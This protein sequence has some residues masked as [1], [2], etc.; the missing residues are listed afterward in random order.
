M[1]TKSEMRNEAIKRMTTLRLSKE[2]MAVFKK[3]KVWKSM[4]CGALYELTD[5]EQKIVDKFENENDCIV[6]HAIY[7]STEFGELFSM[8]FVSKYEEEWEFDNADLKDNYVFAMVENLTDPWYSDMGSI[9]VESMFG[10]LVRT[11]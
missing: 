1:P 8:L 11:A 3:G 4:W 7:T 6:Y 10:G 9:K 2:C 5:E